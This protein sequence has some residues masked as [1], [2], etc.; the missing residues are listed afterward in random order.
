MT[1]E[2]SAEPDQTG[3]EEQSNLNL[4]FLFLWQTY[5]ESKIYQHMFR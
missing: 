4:H 1:W 3:Y 2:K 5:F